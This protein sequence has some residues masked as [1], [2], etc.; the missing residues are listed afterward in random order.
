MTISVV[1]AQFCRKEK[2][3]CPEPL[4]AAAKKVFSDVEGNGD[5]GLQI[6][7]ELLVRLFQFVPNYFKERSAVKKSSFR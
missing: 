6:L 5:I 4:S 1:L 2:E 7:S 3:F